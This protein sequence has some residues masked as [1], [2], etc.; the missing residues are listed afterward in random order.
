LISLNCKLEPQ[1]GLKIALVVFVILV[2]CLSFSVHSVESKHPAHL[3]I[4]QG[5]VVGID[6]EFELPLL[7]AK[8]KKINSESP[9]VTRLKGF[10][11][12]KQSSILRFSDFKGKVIYIDFWASWCAPCLVSMP[13]LNNLRNKYKEAGFEVI[14]I[15]LDENPA[16]AVKF[17]SAMSIAYPVV[18]DV[19]GKVAKQYKVNGLPSAFIID[20]NGQ[21]KLIHKGFKKSDINFIEANIT[22]F[23]DEIE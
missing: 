7:L 23:L 18:S 6:T 15:N 21:L 17:M 20:A 14:A 16:L 9:L 22:K 13:L 2:V 3:A 8:N 12:F 4:K 10:F 1:L 11:Q 19:D 5:G